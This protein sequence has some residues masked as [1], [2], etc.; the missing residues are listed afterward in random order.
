MNDLFIRVKHLISS[1][2]FE[3]LISIAIG[4][5][6]IAGVLISIVL[7]EE[8]PLVKL[9]EVET[10]DEIID[11][12]LYIGSIVGNKIQQATIDM[13]LNDSH[14]IWFDNTTK[15]WEVTDNRIVSDKDY[16]CLSFYLRFTELEKMGENIGINAPYFTNIDKTTWAN[17]EQV[18][19]V[20]DYTNWKKVSFKVPANDFY[21]FAQ[22]NFFANNNEIK[23]SFEIKQVRFEYLDETQDTINMIPEFGV[24]VQTKTPAPDAVDKNYKKLTKRGGV[25]Y[26]PSGKETYYNLK[27]DGVVRIM[28]KAGY[29][30]Q[31]YPYNVREDGVKCLGPYIM[32]AANLEKHQRGSLVET[33]LGTGIVCDTGEAMIEN[34]DIIDIAVNW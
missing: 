27:M 25:G 29:T 9:P 1:N 32:V 13:G 4:I 34:P 31:E 7:N 10:V 19:N 6:I 30:E 17:N 2:L 20:L 3:I 11:N 22:I 24:L 33:T 26:G 28:R 12:N 15:F 21:G 18:L 23:G 16:V 8:Q 14:Y 5:I